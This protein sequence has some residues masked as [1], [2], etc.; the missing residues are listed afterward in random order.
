[1]TVDVQGTLTDAVL[2]RVRTTGGSVQKS[3]L[4]GGNAQ[5][6]LPLDQVL[7]TAALP[8]VTVFWRDGGPGHNLCQ[9]VFDDSSATTIDDATFYDAP[10]T[11]SWR[12]T[13]PLSSFLRENADG[14][15]ESSVVDEAAH[16]T[17]SIRSVSLHLSGLVTSGT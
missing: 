15:W 8:Q 9:A 4:R 12:P 7:A 1:M 16:D 10:F 17:G 3:Q 14:L 11:G 6:T 5:V 13:E 2:N